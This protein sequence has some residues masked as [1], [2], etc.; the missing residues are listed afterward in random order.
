MMSTNLPIKGTLQV[1]FGPY[2]PLPINDI[3]LYVNGFSRR[4]FGAM[5]LSDLIILVNTK[6]RSYI[7]LIMHICLPVHIRFVRLFIRQLPLFH[8]V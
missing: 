6:R 8:I 1:L 7:Q 5:H 4:I 3:K 2:K